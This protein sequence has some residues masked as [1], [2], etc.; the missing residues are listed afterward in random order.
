MRDHGRQRRGGAGQSVSPVIESPGG[1]A[2]NQ[3]GAF[4]CLKE[5]QRHLCW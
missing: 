5:L 3:L 4:G 2:T 1:S